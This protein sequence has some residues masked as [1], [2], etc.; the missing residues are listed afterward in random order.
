MY[1]CTAALAYAEAVLTER[2]Y[3][4]Q[5]QDSYPFG[6]HPTRVS[7]VHDHMNRGRTSAFSH[8][9]VQAEAKN[10]ERNWSY[11]TTQRLN[12][13]HTSSNCIVNASCSESMLQQTLTNA[14]CHQIADGGAVVAKVMPPLSHSPA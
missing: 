13:S 1:A 2:K 14:H 3:S 7:C 4:R 10:Y 12:P 9:V 8:A 11:L 5:T 6:L